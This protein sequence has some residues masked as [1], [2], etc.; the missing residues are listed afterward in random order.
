[1]TTRNARKHLKCDKII[2]GIEAN[3][4]DFR[5]FI[6]LGKDGWHR[7]LAQMYIIQYGHVD[8]HLRQIRKIKADAK[9]PKK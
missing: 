7:N 8:R 9:F 3:E 6:R 4:G 5:A 2:K 1:M